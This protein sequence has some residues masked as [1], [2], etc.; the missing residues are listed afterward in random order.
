MESKPD[1]TKL[2]TTTEEE[3]SPHLPCSARMIQYI[4]AGWKTLRMQVVPQPVYAGAL[5]R[6]GEP[7]I[8]LFKA[9]PYSSAWVDEMEYYFS[10]KNT[11]VVQGMAPI[12]IT[13]EVWLQEPWKTWQEHCT[14]QDHV[15]YARDPDDPEG[16][17]I[18]EEDEH[19]DHCHQTYVAYEATPRSGYRPIPD[20]SAITY[21][22]ESSPI[23]QN[24]RLVGGWHPATT[25]PKWA[26]R[27]TLRIE[28]V[29]VQR[30]Q[31]ITDQEITDM[32]FL[33]HKLTG[34]APP[35]DG[36][37][38]EAY[39]AYFDRYKAPAG[40]P[41]TE[42]PWVFVFDFSVLRRKFFGFYP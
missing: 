1:E 23:T 36:R 9:G 5:R 26:S 15:S 39:A 7:M 29:R 10:E 3:P 41:W 37:A 28:K 22:H 31:E 6:L 19:S 12:F 18:E 40:L 38:R 33:H 35:E 17:D 24:P 8:H 16:Y 2:Q 27:L 14:P 21:L 25:M 34:E 11:S 20:E 13:E 4:L 30:I 32:L 42:N